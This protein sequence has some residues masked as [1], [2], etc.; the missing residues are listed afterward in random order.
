MIHECFYVS[1]SDPVGG[2]SLD[3]ANTGHAWCSLTYGGQLTPTITWHYTT[4][5]ITIALNGSS[6]SQ[7]TS[8]LGTLTINSTINVTNLQFGSFLQCYIHFEITKI[9]NASKYTF[10]WTSQAFQGRVKIDKTGLNL[11]NQ[12]LSKLIL[13]AL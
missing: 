8:D 10:N 9:I 13:F 2:V 3:E 12:W 11:N 7:S 4:N 5:E 1:E 6:S